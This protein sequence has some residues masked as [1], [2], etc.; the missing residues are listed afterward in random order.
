MLSSDGVLRTQNGLDVLD[1]NGSQIILPP[2]LDAIHISDDGVISGRPQGLT[3][4]L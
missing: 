3:Q 4:M 2:M 1:E